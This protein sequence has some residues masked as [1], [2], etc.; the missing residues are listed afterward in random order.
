V[1]TKSY[2]SLDPSGLAIGGEA[3]A[4]TSAFPMAWE[5]EAQRPPGSVTDD[6]DDGDDDTSMLIR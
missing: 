3:Y 4:I 1:S 5:V 2:V 6:N